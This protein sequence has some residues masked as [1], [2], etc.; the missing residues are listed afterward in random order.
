MNCNKVS[1][2]E[3]LDYTDND[4][5]NKFENNFEKNAWTVEHN[6]IKLQNRIMQRAMSIITSAL[7]IIKVE[8]EIV[9]LKS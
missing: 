8:S 4:L 5:E 9:I 1:F 7:Q 3:L 2:Q 6:A